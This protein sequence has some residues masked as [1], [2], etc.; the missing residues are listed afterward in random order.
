MTAAMGLPDG[1][2]GLVAAAIDAYGRSEPRTAQSVAG[3]LGP[4]DLGFCR[5]KAALMT[6]G[7]P[8]SDSRPILAAQMGTAFHAYAGAALKAT[9]PE[10]H[11]EEKRVTARFPN[12]AE[13]S[14]TPDIVTDNAVIDIKTCDGVSEYRR[15]G[16]TLNHRYQRHT[17]AMGAI[18]EGWLDPSEPIIVGNLYFD[19]RGKDAPLWLWEHFDESLTAEIDS[20]LSDVIYAVAHN[21]EASR[22]IPAPV[23][24]VICEHFTTCRG[25]LP[26]QANDV[27]TDE[28]L[29]QLAAMYAE[30]REQRKAADEM[31]RVARSGLAGVNGMAGKWQV[32]WNEI[33]SETT[34]EITQR[35]DVRRAR[36][37]Q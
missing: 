3:I 7:R 21:E 20:W 13:V 2:G 28:R 4:S 30:G 15:L 14:G 26:S 29:I 33:V 27:V 18:A 22:D 37:R 17:Y 9:F 10:W 1:I 8:Q 36:R 24:E 32:R 16:P 6:A 34:G 35:L 31:M 25:S 19:R 5:M 11:I 12:G 23:C